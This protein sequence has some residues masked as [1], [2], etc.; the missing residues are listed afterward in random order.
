[1]MIMTPAAHYHEAC[2]LLAAADAFGCPEAPD[3]L[4]LYQSA[5]AHALLATVDLQVYSDAKDYASRPEKGAR[6]RHLVDPDSL[7]SGQA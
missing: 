3:T 7:E 1:M 4:A 2:K 5:T 6:V